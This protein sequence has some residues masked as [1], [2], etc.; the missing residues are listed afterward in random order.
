MKK[1]IDPIFIE[2]GA[3]ILIIALTF[4][5]LFFFPEDKAQTYLK[6]LLIASTI[7]LL[8]GYFKSRRLYIES[9]LKTEQILKDNAE[10]LSRQKTIDLFFNN[11]ADGIL[12]LDNE[13]KII[14]FSPG[15]E[16]LSGY[17]KDEA[18]GKKAQEL[19]KFKGDSENSLLPD[20][21]FLPKDLKKKPYLKNT[22]MTKLGKEIDIEA[23]YALIDEENSHKALAVIRDITYE[24]E[25]VKR[26]K[27]FIAITSHQ[28]NTPLSIIR[29]YVSL[30]KQNE[31]KFTGEQKKYI[32]E[33]YG[34]VK[35]MIALVERLLSISRIEEEKIKLEKT[36]INVCDLLEKLK[37][38]Y[39]FTDKTTL[40]FEMPDKNLI[41][42]ADGDKLI[43]VLSNVID[44]AI[45]YT[46]KGEVVV[47]VKTDQKKAKFIV[48]DNG[49]GIPPDDLE[50]IGQKF[51]RAQNAIDI[52]NKGTGLG[53]F[54]AK[55]IILKHD[56][57]MGIESKLGH[58]TKLTI[59]LPIN[60]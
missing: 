11:S 21:V 42:F 19:L 7:I 37:E 53:L 26:D 55:T 44:N 60:S 22:L 4:I 18:I 40:K 16:K 3:W 41:I 38:N 39:R 35:K 31:E 10:L 43:Q 14:S 25:L 5:T 52:D 28:L 54:I 20:A 30:I 56:G 34:S 1:N 6:Y 23:S 2:G 24:N 33:I 36:D 57:K 49:I 50:K 59:E 58:G 13:Q 32:D 48:S 29:G 45:K 15:M 17:S 9:R 51:Y 12:I 27:E 47:S 46:P 8:V